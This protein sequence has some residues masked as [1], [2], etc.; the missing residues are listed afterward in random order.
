MLMPNIS[1]SA[2]DS[3]I[4]VSPGG[5]PKTVRATYEPARMGGVGGGSMPSVNFTLRFALENVF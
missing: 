2:S 1:D 4:W 3:G 5:R